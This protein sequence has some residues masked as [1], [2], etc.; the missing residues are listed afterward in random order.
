MVASEGSMKPETSP[1]NIS[2]DFKHFNFNS[3][4]RKRI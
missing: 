3:I 2:R 4:K 1:L